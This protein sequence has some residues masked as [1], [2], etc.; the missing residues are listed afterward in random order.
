[1]REPVIQRQVCVHARQ[2][3][4]A[5]QVDKPICRLRFTAVQQ[6]ATRRLNLY[7]V[8]SERK[9]EQCAFSPA[10]VRRKSKRRV[11]PVQFPLDL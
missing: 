2:R 1:M 10:P 11:N 7:G 4:S 5:P 8:M 9:A 3:V 6:L